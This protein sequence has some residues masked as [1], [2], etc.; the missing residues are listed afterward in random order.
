MNFVIRL[1]V[2]LVAAYQSRLATA[3]LR[4]ESGQVVNE[5]LGLSVLAIIA[6]VAIGAAL[7]LLGLDIVDWIRTQLGV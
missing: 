5:W 3:D 4:S 6:I 7:K 1:W 2:R